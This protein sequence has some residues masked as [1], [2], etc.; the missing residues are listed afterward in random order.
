MRRAVIASAL[1]LWS[2]SVG[3]QTISQ[4]GFVDGRGFW[5]PQAAPNDA[6]P[7]IEDV[8]FREEVFVKPA[9]WIQFAA[10]LDL[11]ANSHDQVEDAWRLD[12]T[13]R[14]VRRPRAAI[15]RLTAT[16]TAGGFT[17][18]IGKQFI[19]WGRADV[20][21][22][23]DR[24]APRDFLNVI[25]T[26]F[27]PVMGVRPL[28]QVGKET[29][30]AVWVPRMT[31]S[32]LPLF[33]QRWTVLPTELQAIPIEDSGSDV[34]KRSEYG[35]RWNHVGD[36]V[37]TALSYFDGYNHLPN[38]ESRVRPSPMAIEL[39]RVYPALRGYGADLAIPTHWVTLKGEAEYFTS[40]SSTNEEYVLY[41]V[42]VERQTGEWV[43]V[44]G[45]AGEVV[46]TSHAGFSFAPDRGIAR[47]ILG[48]ASYTV[49]PR[50]TVAIEGAVRQSGA[51]FYVKG[52]YSEAFGQHWRLTLTGVGIAGDENDFLG[53]FHR[54]SHGSVALRFSF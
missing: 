11:R 39:S 18:D 7:A 37:E 23:T 49:D 41:V 35:V 22:P 19:R 42:E 17:L 33:N 52:E 31:P 34:P 50:R 26:E 43:L 15:R 45:Y 29:F 40:P 20:L 12:F 6:T 32:R 51:G 27:L 28:L 36:R 38:I 10:G 4:R 3:A 53:E 48:R 13:D 14:G 9:G 47:S 16:F 2:S 8:L 21:N 25:D 30:E 46:T 1:V 5:F 54:D 44:G 24:F